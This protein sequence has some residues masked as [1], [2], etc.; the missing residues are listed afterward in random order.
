MN[1]TNLTKI[2][3]LLNNGIW[4]GEEGRISERRPLGIGKQFTILI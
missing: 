2:F 3:F 4:N 1:K